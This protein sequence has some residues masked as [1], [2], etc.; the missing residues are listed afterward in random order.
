[1]NRL[2][3]VTEAQHNVPMTWNC[4][5]V[6]LRSVENY[7]RHLAG[8][9][10]ETARCLIDYFPKDWFTGDWDRSHVSVHKFGNNYGL[11][12]RHGKGAD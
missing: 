8:K 10:G 11:A 3:E 2:L 4:C 1:V 6:G 5:A 12:T 9:A 7:S